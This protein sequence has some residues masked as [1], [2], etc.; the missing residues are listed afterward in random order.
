[1][2]R[3]AAGGQLRRETVWAGGVFSGASR[4]AVCGDFAERAGPAGNGG[5][6]GGGEAAGASC[7]PGPGRGSRSKGPPVLL[8]VGCARVA[9][10]R[11]GGGWERGVRLRRGRWEPARGGSRN[12]WGGGAECPWPRCWGDGDNAWLP[13]P[14]HAGPGT[15]AGTSPFPVS[16]PHTPSNRGIR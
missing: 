16:W 10:N 14:A 2:P 9:V 13:P 1:M 3:R 5:G 4:G 7:L 12:A 15:I 8:N 6:G 11:G